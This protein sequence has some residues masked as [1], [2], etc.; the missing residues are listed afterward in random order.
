M[1][2]ILTVKKA[3]EVSQTLR[4]QGKRIVL[5]GGCFDILHIGHI[6]YLEK[7][8]KEGDVLFVMLENDETV[9]HIKGD[10]RPIHKQQERAYMLSSLSVVDYVILLPRLE[11]DQK[12]DT[13]IS[14]IRPSVI[15]ITKGD[16]YIR[17]KQ[18]QARSVGGKLVDVTKTISNKSTTRLAQILSLEN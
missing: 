4:E 10:N 15:A 3:I 6:E 5:A 2:K 11:T 9:K 14:Q 16:P 7:A 13:L 17:K 12:Y 8:K 1:S 18:K